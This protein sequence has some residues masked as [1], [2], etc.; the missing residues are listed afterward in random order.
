MS[1][2]ASVFTTVSVT[3]TGQHPLVFGTV[4]QAAMSATEQIA[5]LEAFATQSTL[6]RNGDRQ[7]LHF[8]Q[9]Q[10]QTLSENVAKLNDTLAY[11]M[12]G[13]LPGPE[14]EA[15]IHSALKTLD[16]RQ[17]S[18]KDFGMAWA[19]K[20]R[21]SWPPE[22]LADNDFLFAVTDHLRGSESG[23]PKTPAA[24]MPSQKSA[25][26]PANPLASVGKAASGS[27]P[28]TP[29]TVFPFTAAVTGRHV[30]IDLPRPD[31]FSKIAVGSDIRAW[32]LRMHEYLTIAG[33]EP[34]TWVVVAS[35]YLERSPRQL[36]EARKTQLIEQPE[37]LYSWDNFREWCIASFSPHNHEKHA[38]SKLESL[39]QTG[40]VAEY[41][42]EHNVL[43]SQSNFPMQLRIYWWERGLKDEIR[44]MCRVDPLT[45]KEYTD[46]DKAQTAACACDA[47]LD[48]SASAAARKHKLTS[49]RPSSAYAK[50]ENKK[51]KFTALLPSS[52]RNEQL[53][54][55]QLVQ[56]TG[57][58]ADSF[59]VPTTTGRLVEPVPEFFQNW[60]EARQKSPAGRTLL[61]QEL[62]HF[63]K[64]GSGTSCLFKGCGQ[65]GHA[66]TVCPKLALAIAKN[67][68][69]RNY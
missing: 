37:V 68:S 36:W 38:I 21:P 65:K 66:W 55:A 69:V 47:H 44:Q 56:W 61:P 3:E 29:S 11:S 6:D 50:V 7:D 30:K 26:V 8:L 27:M 20:V 35:G 48:Y 32:I 16:G 57:D 31:K 14:S 28:T 41:M 23:V 67:P 9:E 15:E 13:V 53:P 2:L 19:A 43:A 51:A 64:R 33:V 25:E 12:N 45:Y 10:V 1:D 24:P 42:A 34:N 5:R 46:I 60:I 63:A 39:R 17:K 59:A 18:V 54:G 62:C 40:S 49:P 4:P 52:T 22:A 58:S